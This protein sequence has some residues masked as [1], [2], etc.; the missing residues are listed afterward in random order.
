MLTTYNPKVMEGNDEA[1]KYL[2]GL[3]WDTFEIVLSTLTPHL[4]SARN[5]LPPESQVLMMC[6]RLRLNLPFQYLNMQTDCLSAQYIT[7]LKS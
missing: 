1:A 2:T 4:Q 3:T 6:V 5:K 7:F